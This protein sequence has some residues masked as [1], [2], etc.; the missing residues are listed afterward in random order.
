MKQLQAICNSSNR[1][2]VFS[3]A[4]VIPLADVKSKTNIRDGITKRQSNETFHY[5]VE[6]FIPFAGI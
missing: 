4:K 2:F 5:L 6:N 3:S 1:E